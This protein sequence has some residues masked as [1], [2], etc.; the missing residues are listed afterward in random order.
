MTP[1]QILADHIPPIVALAQ[2]L[3]QLMLQA[4]PEAREAAYPGWHAIGYRHP[5][6]GYFCGIFPYAD[7]LKLYFE[8]GKFLPDPEHRLQGDGRQTRYLVIESPEN[9]HAGYISQLV[10]D[11]IALKSDTARTSKQRPASM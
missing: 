6:A 10:K 1:E 2:R 4:A 11:S 5:Q 7:H 3:R 8:Y 9:I